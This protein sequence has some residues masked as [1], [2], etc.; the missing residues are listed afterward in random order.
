MRYGLIGRAF[1][2]ILCTLSSGC[3]L[4]AQEGPPE[5]IREKTVYVPYEK[6]QA[7][8]E[9]KGRGIFLPYEEFLE[10]WQAAQPK[11]PKP[12]P[13]TP[14]A[15]AV[16]RGG[17]Y[18]GQVAA[19]GKTARFT[20]ECEVEA[21][22]KGW[23]EIELPFQNVAVESVSLS[24]AKALFSSRPA[25]DGSSGGYALFLPQAGRYQAT[26]EFSV[27]VVPEP[28]KKTLSFGI[29]ATAVS[30]LELSIPEE[31]VRVNVEPVL[32]V[33]QQK[34]LEKTTQVLAFLGNSREVSVTWMPPA[35]KVSGDGAVVFAEQSIRTYLGERI[36]GIGT[37]IRYQVHRGQVDTLR[38]RIPEA[39]RLLAVRGDNIR[40]W[41]EEDGVLV[42][43]LHSPLE[44]TSYGLSLS[45]ERILP[46]TPPTLA[47]PFPR[48]EEVT[49]E[50]GFV[51][52]GHEDGLHVRV[53]DRTSLSQLDRDEVP[54]PLR[55]NAL[56]SF[57]YQAHPIALELQVEKITPVIRSFT[58]S[59]VSLGRDEDVWIG[60]IDYSIT[61]AGVFRFDIRVPSRWSVESVGEEGKVEDFQT[62]DSGDVRTIQVSLKS[63]GIGNFRLP[64]HLTADGSAVTGET[65]H[66]PPIVVGST[67]DRGLFG[68]SA[69]RAIDVT[70]IS[71]EKMVSAAVDQ[72]FNAGIMSQIPEGSSN[73]LTYSYREQPASV[74]LDLKAKTTEIDALA[75]HLVEIADGGIKFTH[76]IDFEIL[77]AAVDRLTFSAPTSLD[78]L[79]K[80]EAKEKKEVRRVGTDEDRTLWEIVLQAPTL[81]AVSVTV[82]HERELKG[83][84][85]GRPYAHTVPIIHATEVRSEKGFVAIR[86]EGT[87]EIVPQP[88]NMEPIEAG[89]LSDKLRR[90]QIY[91]A[92]RY[93]AQDP[94]LDL[95]LTRYEYQPLATT[96]VNL[97]R[98][99]SALSEE[100]KLKTQAML[101][102]QNTDRQFLELAL[103]PET[104]LS[105]SVAGKTQQ[106]RKRKDGAGT[107]IQIPPGAFPVVF[108]YEEKL[109]DTAMGS[110]GGARMRTVEVLEGVPVSKLEL[111]L[112]LPPEYTYLRWAGNLRPRKSTAP[113]LWS[114]FKYLLAQATGNA[115]GVAAAATQQA[116][117]FAPVTVAGPL[118]VNVPTRG[119]VPFYFET[120]APVGNLSF[121][122]VDRSI[123]SLGD[124]VA[125]LGAIALGY[126]LLARR[127]WPASR[128]AILLVF[129]PLALTW[130]ATGPLVEVFTSVLAGGVAALAV[131]VG[132]QLTEKLRERRAER[133]AFAPDPYLEEAER[134]VH[135][136]TEAKPEPPQT[137]RDPQN[138]E[139][140]EK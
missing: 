106:P 72:L 130:F 36:L 32:A 2:Y 14:P 58:T 62:T 125:F 131:T 5:V 133:L 122:Y 119:S 23:S 34:T 86:K 7:V 71:R 103:P 42:V 49:R 136:K 24:D 94:S 27:R 113:S 118:D 56:V 65:T 11:P 112:Y 63:K 81:G 101:F 70:T 84:E 3:F 41:L 76:I 87:L 47:V 53:A 38:V 92:F 13:D 77:Y 109:A 33:T 138:P 45:F 28:G 104:I 135:E 1:L 80:V 52:L 55:K 12:E 83:L 129:L 59:V 51:T 25:A 126:F 82:N 110:L 79:L 140:E 20:F 99:K 111:E 48:V 100:R 88:V 69:P 6:L 123:Y 137:P 54:E 43:R 60:W 121:T 68:V 18:T 16:I 39:T 124:F 9:Q 19:D 31:D 128:V 46:E 50:S 107:L 97:I 74:K 78:N 95:T 26:L 61:R 134:T 29:P 114:R 90:G 75:Q 64:F 132:M 57:R 67:E 17:K 35:G 66:S 30:R 85:S 120:M 108:V 96:V 115:P 44:A 21:L 98:L 116:A 105:M 89:A 8:F 93:F 40:E 10:L 102:V 15:D 37:E 117:P 4:L 91:S 139:T 22:K 127:R 73:P